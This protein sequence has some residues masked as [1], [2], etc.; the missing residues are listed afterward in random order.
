MKGFWIGLGLGASLEVRN[1]E[2]EEVIKAMCRGCALRLVGSCDWLCPD[3][4]NNNTKG[5]R[6][7]DLTTREEVLCGSA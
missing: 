1:G 2:L 4:E 6:A 5:L 3:R 7:V